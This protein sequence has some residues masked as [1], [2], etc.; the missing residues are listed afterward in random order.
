MKTVMCG[1]V[2]SK[3]VH[4]G[5]GCTSTDT[6]N[7]QRADANRSMLAASVKPIRDHKA[8][9][10]DHDR[11]DGRECGES[12]TVVELDLIFTVSQD[13]GAV[14]YEMHTPNRY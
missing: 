1:T 13:N 9:E 10:D 8:K 3:V 5:D 14:A 7:N 4:L 11:D 12:R 2:V 6:A